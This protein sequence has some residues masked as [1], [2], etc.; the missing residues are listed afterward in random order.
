MVDGRHSAAMVHRDG[1]PVDIGRDADLAELLR[2]GVL[3]NDA[4]LVGAEHALGD[5]TEAALL[6][7]ATAFGLDE[8][9]V[10]AQYPRLA[11]IP[12]DGKRK[13]MSTLHTEG[14]G[15]LVVCKGAPE[16]MIADRAV[17]NDAGELAAAESV[18]DAWARAGLRVLAFA[19]AHH[20]SI[21]ALADL[22]HGLTLIGL[23]GI[24][25]PPRETANEVVAACRRAGIVPVLVT[26][27]HVATAAAIAGRVGIVDPPG[28]ALDLTGLDR[29][30]VEYHADSSVLARATPEHKLQLIETWQSR[31]DVVAMT[32]DGVNDGP[33]LRRADIG[34]AMGRRGTEVARQAADLVLAN[35]DLGT[36]IAAVEEGRRV[37]A[38]IRR[39]LLYG[40]SGGAAEVIVMLLG[41]LLG[42]LVPLLP[43]Q[44][45]WIN[46]LTHG[47]VGVALG[48]EPTDPARM[49]EPPRPPA[50]S[51]LGAGLWQRIMVAAAILSAAS[52]GA[53]AWVGGQG[54]AT[55]QTTLFLTLGASQLAV[56]LAVRAPRQRLT[57]DPWLFL[58]VLGAAALLVGAT[59]VAP[60]REILGL[61]AI[62]GEPVL[63]SAVAA[64]VAYAMIRAILRR[65]AT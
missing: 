9:A 11:E 47:L 33:A 57:Q 54:S 50:E 49:R 45:L 21:P 13:R 22:E 59:A 24:A 48:A 40:I 39:F 58:A 44:I 60:L 55:W 15:W 17:T 52:L 31:G 46:L 26:G 34:V 38:N 43:A 2:A 61:S 29:S 42:F 27:D 14:A 16:Q 32:G 37:Y 23:A 41:P 6:H 62:A 51:V 64:V 4:T 7:V 56:A 53:A 10:E 3:C 18:A 12:F 28:T 36:V 25:D 1:R 19:V 8:L 30:G 65:W 5:P 20:R 63:V 35:D